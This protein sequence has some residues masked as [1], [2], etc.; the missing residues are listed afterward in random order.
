MFFVGLFSLKKTEIPPQDFLTIIPGKMFE[1][2]IYVNE[3]VV[4]E[5]R[6][7]DGQADA[8]PINGAKQGRGSEHGFWSEWGASL[9]VFHEIK[10]SSK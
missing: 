3:R 10:A 1:P 5:I 7:C 2:L 8:H 9:V 6:I 4:L